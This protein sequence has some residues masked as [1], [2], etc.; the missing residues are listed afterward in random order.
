MAIFYKQPSTH[1][2]YTTWMDVNKNNSQRH[3][4]IATKNHQ[5]IYLFIRFL[6]KISQFTKCT[7]GFL[8]NLYTSTLYIFY[9]STKH[10]WM[11]SEY[12]S[13]NLVILEFEVWIILSSF[14]NLLFVVIVINWILLPINRR[15]LLIT[16]ITKLI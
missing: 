3:T 8:S 13:F 12:N 1:T 2:L 6:H 14:Y 16:I 9:P 7:P 11:N 10:S 15:P 5:M 4:I